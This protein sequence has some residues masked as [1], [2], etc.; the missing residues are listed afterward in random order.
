MLLAFDS[1]A[2]FIWVL[3]VIDGRIITAEMDTRTRNRKIS[4][5]VENPQVSLKKNPLSFL[6]HFLPQ[7]CYSESSRYVLYIIEPYNDGY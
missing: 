4:K 7:I 5:A 3:P 6:L 2:D 1:R